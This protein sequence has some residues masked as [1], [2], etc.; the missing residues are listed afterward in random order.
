MP[1]REV[2]GDEGALFMSTPSSKLSTRPV[3]VAKPANTPP[4]Q[5]DPNDEEGVEEGW[6]TPASLKGWGTSFSFHALLVVG[7]AFWYFVPHSNPPRAFDS[8][9]AG[10]EMGVDEGLTA[11]GGLNTPLDMSSAPI[12]APEPVLTALAPPELNSIGPKVPTPAGA[13]KASAGGGM[14]NNNPGAG[15]GDG[16][17]LARVGQGGENIRGVAVKVGDPQF[18]LLWDSE[19]DL[20]LHVIEP[21]GKEIYW[22]DP[23][24]MKGGEL[25]VD[26]TKGFG[27]ENIYWLRAAEGSSEKVLGPGPPGEYKWFVVYWGGF[28]GIARPT[29]W[30]VRIKHDGKVQI[31]TGRFKAL[32]ERSRIY[33]LKVEP[34]AAGSESAESSN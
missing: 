4:V 1:V 27:P 12:P 22:E 15:G 14:D 9:L 18:T 30:K 23:K 5:I 34:K 11:T 32:N 33:T 28:G 8:R 29:K 21:G 6:F 3:P 19:V 13:E 16:F 25:D 17:G 24:G 31:V 10:S 7:M 2:T 26:N 20:D